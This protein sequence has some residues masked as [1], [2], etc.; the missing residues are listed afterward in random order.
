[1][2][3]ITTRNKVDVHTAYHTL[4]SDRNTDGGSFLPMRLPRLS[5][6]EIKSLKEKSFGEIVAQILNLFFSARLD[7]ADVECCVGRYPVKMVSMSHKIAIGELWHNPDNDFS[8]LVRNLSG[9]ILGAGDTSDKPSRWGR[10]SVRI[11]ILFA[12]YGKLSRHGYLDDDQMFDIAVA[13]DDFSAPISVWY[14][15]EMGLPVGTIICSGS[16]NSTLWDLVHHGQM[17]T[18][19]APAEFERLIFGLFGTDGATGFRNAC[20]NC[21]EYA[22]GE[23][24]LKRLRQEM[25]YAVVSRERIAS[26]IHN[27]Y[28]TNTYLADPNSALAY[29][30]L[31]DYRV[32][33]G[34][35]RL[36]LILSEKSP[37][38]ASDTALD[39][40]RTGEP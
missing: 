23:E 39:S 17:Q 38:S 1:M 10:I 19:C 40:I 28:R 21:D 31:Q 6:D 11:A 32:R 5:V 34:E 24:G 30:G 12:L 15:R 29:A 33:A 16:E 3:Y 7:S 9:R 27:L 26:V 14:A 25:F 13:Q 8:R 37:E 35:A 36:C 18:S 2:L 20:S 22:L 4:C